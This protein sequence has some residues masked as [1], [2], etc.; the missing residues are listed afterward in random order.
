MIVKNE[1]KA[2]V[3]PP[4]VT[5]TDFAMGRSYMISGPK[6]SFPGTTNGSSKE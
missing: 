6:V 2:L 1:K 4:I 3:T 5:L